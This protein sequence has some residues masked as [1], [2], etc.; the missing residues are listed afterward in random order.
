MTARWMTRWKPAVGWASRRALDEQV[1]E[2][3]VEIFDDARAQGVEIDVAGAHD[4]RGVAV[5]EQRQQQVL[6]RG[7]FVVALVGVRQR[8]VQGRFETLRE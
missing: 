6:Q 3:V 5:V 2:L 1:G 7:V 4:G 8:A